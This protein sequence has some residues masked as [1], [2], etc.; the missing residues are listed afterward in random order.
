MHCRRI[1]RNTQ[2]F[3]ILTKGARGSLACE[4]TLHLEDYPP[5][6]DY[7]PARSGARV[8][9][10]LASLASLVAGIISAVGITLNKLL[11]HRGVWEGRDC[12]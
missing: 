7:F 10:W 4:K 5:S 2:L 11:K 12:H 3:P 9:S 6:P 1:L 8:F